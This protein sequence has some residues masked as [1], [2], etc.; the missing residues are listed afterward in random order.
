VKP[1][2][3]FLITT[4]HDTPARPWH[5][6]N[7]D[8]VKRAASAYRGDDF[9]VADSPESADFLLFVDSD[10]PFL[11]DV[12]RSPLYRRFVERSFV[13]NVSDAAI[14]VVAGMYPDLE[15][16]LR[17]PELQLGAFYLRSF[18]NKA[19]SV[20]PPDRR[21]PKWLFSFVGNVNTS[22]AVRGRILALQHSRGFL[23]NRSS[24]LRDDD[25][26]FVETLRNSKF[27]ICPKGL[28]PT[29]WRF[30]ET[31]MA[32]RAP[33]IVS[34]LWVPARDIDWPSF[35]IHVPERDVESIPAICETNE[36]R[37]AAMGQRA[38][39][40]WERNCSLENAFGW[41]GRRLRE[42]R[43]ARDARSLRLN[44]EMLRELRFHGQV[45]KYARWRTGKLLRDLRLR[46]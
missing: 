39:E 28:G 34:D 38:R 43:E 31:M 27:V 13:H 37:A 26:D 42:L 41:I 36:S 35:S 12:M 24:G 18:D 46:R 29:S 6:A 40:E 33:V 8:R 9:R 20:P 7:L 10:E 17:R 2:S 16:P 14:P 19:L 25:L 5:T 1:D 3:V 32:G 30:Y 4:A 15:G 11:G 22:P 45:A 23:L 44:R 21:E